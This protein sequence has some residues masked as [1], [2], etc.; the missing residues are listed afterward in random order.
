[1]SKNLVPGL[2]DMGSSAGY[3]RTWR[4]DES[5]GTNNTFD[6]F[7][8]IYSPVIIGTQGDNT[9]EMLSIWTRPQF[10]IGQ[11]SVKEMSISSSFPYY[12]C[13]RLFNFWASDNRACD[14][15]E[16]GTQ[17]PSNSFDIFGFDR[18]I[19]IGE[20]QDTGPLGETTNTD[21]QPTEG[22]GSSVGSSKVVSQ[23]DDIYP[24]TYTQDDEYIEDGSITD[25]AHIKIL[26]NTFLVKD[27]EEQL[28]EGTGEF[29]ANTSVFYKI[30]L[31][32]DGF[33]ESPL[34]DS[35]FEID[36]T[37]ESKFLRLHLQMPTVEEAGLSPRVTHVNLYR[38]NELTEL[39]RLV[40][41]INLNGEDDPFELIDGQY[42]FKIKDEFLMATYEAIN[43]IPES[44]NDLTPNYT[45]SCQLNDF[46]FVSGIG[47]P[48]ISQEG[49][50]MIM[51]SKQSKFSVFDWSNDFLDL[52]T[53]PI[54][55]VAFA[56]RIFAFDENNI[57][58][59]NPQGL[60]I[61]DVSE[62]IGTLNSQ[63][64]V[65][66]DVG[67]FFADR[68]NIYVHN[69]RNASPIGGPILYSQTKPEWQIGY[70]DAIVKA[71]KLGYTPKLTFHPSK[72]LVYVVLQGYG[73]SFTSFRQH[74]SRVYAFNIEQKRW[75]YLE[76]PTAKAITTTSKGDV[77]IG[78]GYQVY[79]YNID[80]RNRK[81]FDW[82]SVPFNMGSTNYDKSFKSL[83]I[84]GDLCLFK[85]NKNGLATQTSSGDGD[86]N[87]D[88]MG[89]NVQEEEQI[90]WL[91]GDNSHILDVTEASEND[92]LKVYV[93]NVLQTMRIQDKKPNIGHYIANDTSG[94]IYQVTTHLPAF[95]NS[96]NGLT[97]YNS[98][99][100]K[101][102][103]S[104]NFNSLPEFLTWPTSQF[105]ETTKQG[106]VEELI[107][108]HKGMYLHFSG[109]RENGEEIEEIVKV[110]DIM[111]FWLQD[112]EGI[113]ELDTSN[114]NAVTIRTWRGQ[115]GTK[116][117]DWN[118]EPYSTTMNS[119][120]VVCPT[121]K[122]PK[123]AKGRDT[124]VV[125]KNQKA[126]I[127]SF[128]ITY[129]PKRFK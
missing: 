107:Y 56:G 53:E 62:G 25:G 93:D 37:N 24:S 113:N 88:D 87:A 77:I 81:S 64:V 121:F 124:K 67:M 31:L 114:S 98:E 119:I 23:K 58:K 111:F 26:K 82:E 40:K 83:K 49:K 68:N 13:D 79:N 75:D 52:P 38:K 71:E 19:K 10:R 115:L 60:Y 109:K 21:L 106:G 74:K 12:I 43:G 127:D 103:F 1:M 3:S 126:S 61:E 50:H 112:D 47:H 2:A 116:A 128:A 30:S 122:Y 8:D 84:S 34:N 46:L 99:E 22:W 20:T 41:S 102:S 63:S 44:L 89:G 73:E 42:V 120:R 29:N 91:V 94:T 48:D 39:Y 28:L 125:F 36:V 72:Q 55:L 16:G 5:T 66:T 70:L 4:H 117:I 65:T 9:K 92:D 17:N 105:R 90:D 32:Y 45:L 96:N 6:R 80:K 129:R 123:G 51:R 101:D 27:S 108:I 110:R 15:D 100:L 97:G 57:Y 118:A 76:I 35:A 7:F 85:F 11:T 14:E 59:I 95:N 54:A 104:L 78:D 18:S 69:G 86:E 33:Q